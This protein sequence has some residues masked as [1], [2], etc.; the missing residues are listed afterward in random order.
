MINFYYFK[1]KNSENILIEN[2]KI[3]IQKYKR[4]NNSKYKITLS[5][6]NIYNTLEKM[7]TQ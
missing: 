5:V 7:K 1:K 2:K 6:N 4:K 3:M